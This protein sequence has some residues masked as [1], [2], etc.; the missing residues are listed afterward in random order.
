MRRR[1]STRSNA[2]VSWFPVPAAAIAAPS[3]PPSTDDRAAAGNPAAAIRLPHM[4]RAFS[5][6]F[7]QDEHGNGVAPQDVSGGGFMF[8]VMAGMVLCVGLAAT[9]AAQ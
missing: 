3:R 5:E 2:T 6:D 4:N 1:C 7:I 8:R 9:A